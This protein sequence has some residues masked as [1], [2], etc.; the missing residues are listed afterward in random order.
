MV[1]HNIEKKNLVFSRVF[2]VSVENVWSLWT[3]PEMVKKWWGPDNFEC[4]IAK[5]DFREGGSSIV[6]MASPKLG[7]PE[8]YSMWRYTKIVQMERIEYVLSLCDKDGNVVD[9]SAA[10]MPADFPK[11]IVN[12]VVFKTLGDNKTEMTITELDW[13]VGKMMEL[14]K[15]GMEQCLSK[16]EKALQ[17]S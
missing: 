17:K 15:M 14:S 5:I 9:P 6:N 11:D 3:D 10:G 16:M 12:I 1:P 13:P 4:T 2:D 7:F 8:Q